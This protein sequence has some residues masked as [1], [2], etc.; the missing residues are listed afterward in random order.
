MSI[1]DDLFFDRLGRADLLTHEQQVDLA[2]RVAVGAEA[3]RRLAAGDDAASLAGLVEA[4]RSARAKMIESNML[5]VVEHAERGQ[6]RGDLDLIDCIH[7]GI[8]GL[9]KAVD[10]FDWTRGY[11]FSTYAKWWI[12]LAVNRAQANTG[13]T[14]RLPV[15]VHDA[16]IRV[17]AASRSVDQTDSVTELA[18]A[19]GLPDRLVEA[20]LAS[21]NVVPAD[22]P[23]MVGAHEEGMSLVDFVAVDDGFED[24]LVERLDREHLAGLL[25]ERL[26][27]LPGEQGSIIRSFFG[28]DGPQRTLREIGESHGYTGEWAGR[29][30]RN[31]MAR[32]A[33]DPAI[34]A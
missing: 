14:I 11:K 26:G 23:T 7:E 24:H 13:S 33:A 27:N 21:P 30:K 2:K 20:A 5:L 1:Y 12:R 9:T 19:T 34:A 32:L 16:R 6:Y 15:K 25:E 17:M 3:A 4:G 22:S 10:R 29:H 18:A 28:I 8:F 31:G